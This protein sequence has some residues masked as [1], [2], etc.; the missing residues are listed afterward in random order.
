MPDLLDACM[1]RLK[2][3]GLMVAGSV[4]LESFCALYG[5][6]PGRRVG[7]CRLD[8]ANERPIAGTHRHLK[9][10]NTI[11]LFIFQKEIPL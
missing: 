9:H 1:E 8:V 4:T 6:R 7:L 2:P 5:W 10:Q 3:G 11:T